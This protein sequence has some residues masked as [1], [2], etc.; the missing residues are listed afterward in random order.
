LENHL[1]SDEDGS[2]DGVIDDRRLTLK[3]KTTQVVFFLVFMGMPACAFA[4]STRSTRSANGPIGVGPGSGPPPGTLDRTTA[5]PSTGATRDPQEESLW[6]AAHQLGLTSDQR[7]ELASVL[8]AEKV[9]RAELDKALQDAR[10]ALADALANG[11][12]FLDAEIENLANAGAKMQEADLKVW[13]KLYAV[14]T[15][16]QQRRLLSM[17]TPLS[18]ASASHAITQDQ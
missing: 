7:A 12:T 5:D 4:Q 18:L 9:E 6:R 16:D 14:L 17:S 3:I 11:Q 15:P 8:N 1:R 10:R 13:A 2:K